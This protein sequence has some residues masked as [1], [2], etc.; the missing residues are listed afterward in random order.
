MGNFV[1]SPYT[2]GKTSPSRHIVYE[3]KPSYKFFPYIWYDVI[4][5]AYETD[6]MYVPVVTKSKLASKVP[7]S[8]AKII[9]KTQEN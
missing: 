6:G 2:W 3:V 5:E 4:E 1:N 8:V 7:L 9:K